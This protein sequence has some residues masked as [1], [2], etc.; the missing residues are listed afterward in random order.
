[1]PSEAAERAPGLRSGDA[2]NG[3]PRPALKEAHG[4]SGARPG[5]PV[6]RTP[7]EPVRSQPDL[8]SGDARAPRS[9]VGFRGC[10]HGEEEERQRENTST[11][12]NSSHEWISYAVLC[13]KKKTCAP[14]RAGRS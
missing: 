6:D 12:L 14:A 8:E 5:D 2:V 1:M 10:G 11:R 13:L 3:D 7:V 9:G 4:M